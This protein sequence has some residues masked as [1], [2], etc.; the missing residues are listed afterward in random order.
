MS[1]KISLFWTLFVLLSQVSIS[2][3]NTLERS[4]KDLRI[5]EK[6]EQKKVDEI[7]ELLYGKGKKET[8]YIFTHL[9]LKKLK[10]DA[11]KAQLNYLLSC[12]FIENKKNADSALYYSKKTLEFRRFSSNFV[13]HHIHLMGTKSL[14]RTYLKSMGLAKQSKKVTIEGIEKAKKWNDISQYD[15]LSYHLASI[16]IFEKKYEKAILL[17]ERTKESTTDFIKIVSL[18][19]LGEIYSE[20]REFRKANEYLEQAW[21]V[22][23]PSFYRLL[24]RLN[25]IKNNKYLIENYNTVSEL[26]KLIR[27][28]KIQGHVNFENIVNKVLVK[29]YIENQK[30]RLAKNI[31]LALLK[32]RSDEGNLNEM[33]YSYEGLRDLFEATKN[34]KKAYLYSEMAMRLKDSINALQKAREINEVEVEYETLK[35]EKENIQLKKEKIEQ[36]YIRNLILLIVGVLVVVIW[37]LVI[38]YYFKLNEQKKLSNE[39]INSLMQEQ[40]LKL[41]KATIQ[42]KDRERA[43]LAKGLHDALG[44]DI[45]TL[46][47]L[48]GE[49]N[50]SNIEKIQDLIDVT[51][52]KVRSMSHNIVPKKNRQQEYVE[53]LEE[54]ITNLDNATDISF[55]FITN[56]ELFLNQLSG[57]MQNEIFMILK[58]LITNTLKHAE[59]S[60][61]DIS[62][63]QVENRLVF[64]YEDNGKGF[65]SVIKEKTKGIGLVNIKDRVEELSGTIIIDSY[66][67]RGTLVKIEIEGRIEF[68]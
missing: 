65:S 31:Y 46:K 30:F 4:I 1:F 16:Y 47:L 6:N 55:H 43:K 34:Y 2:Q 53:V 14:A 26:Q 18:I 24:I 13:E 12:Y 50:V 52:Q 10:T 5:A 62:L 39:K 21:Q 35:K 63:E 7:F 56:G 54:Y 23:N 64:T 45:A 19:A 61:I 44:N 11:A 17:L 58:E 28:S 27:Q 33:L 36:V 68:S 38:G 42:G 15:Y 32:D 41:I 8:A 60:A 48:I 49:V 20:Y 3:K 51:Y 9:S 66:P 67:K 57:H 25:R 59:A 29:E 37:L 40:E 22:T